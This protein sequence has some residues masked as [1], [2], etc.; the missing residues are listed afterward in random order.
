M[1][2][3]FVL[4]A[5]LSLEGLPEE[6]PREGTVITVDL[7]RNTAY[8][9]QDGQLLRSSSVASG[10]EKVLKRGTRF[11]LFRTPRGRHQVVRKIE[12][13]IWMK[14]DWAFI[15]EGKPIPPPDCPTR[16]VKGK[17]GKY[18]LDLG[19][20]ILLHGTDDPKSIGKRVSHGCIRLPADMLKTV[21]N[22]AD[23]GTSVYI[24]ESGPPRR[25][26]VHSDLDLLNAR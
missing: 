18:A 9:F 10:S 26:D 11:W 20:G 19:D 5:A 7:T 14:P 25:N 13:P 17:L 8:L 3:R 2:L 15:E 1:I 22:A 23:V 4:A 6:A 12:N 24:F 16:K 21:Y